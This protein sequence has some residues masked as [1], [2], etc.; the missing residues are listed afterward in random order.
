MSRGTIATRL[1]LIVS[2]VLL[3][4]AGSFAAPHATLQPAPAQGRDNCSN[5]KDKNINKKVVQSLRA[6]FNEEERLFLNFNI[7]TTNGV[8]KLKGGVPGQR[9]FDR[10]IEA[11][12]KVPCV[13]EID[14]RDFS[15][16][17]PQSCDPPDQPC[18]GGCIG[19][20]PETCTRIR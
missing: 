8:V 6:S 11:V 16:T 9:M 1:T 7:T 10:V 20:P 15:N 19:P 4:L 12:K 13:K 5:A 14:R 18:N 3:F 17:R 2:L